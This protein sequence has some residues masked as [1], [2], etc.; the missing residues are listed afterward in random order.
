MNP[1]LIFSGIVFTLLMVFLIIKIKTSTSQKEYGEKLKAKTGAPSELEDTAV[2]EKEKQK[3]KLKL[4]ILGVV[5]SFLVVG[6]IT[7]IIKNERIE[8]VFRVFPFWF[9]F[10]IPIF[11]KKKNKKSEAAIV[12]SRKSIKMIVITMEIS[13]LILALMFYFMTKT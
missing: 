13:F 3:K 2:T 8:S 4:I 7:N 6:F 1:S 12:E 11:A 10:L 5:L 9:I